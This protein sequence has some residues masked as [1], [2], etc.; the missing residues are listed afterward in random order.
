M[1]LKFRLLGLFLLFSLVAFAQRPMSVT[2]VV[3]FIKS[4]IKSN[5][6]DRA[7]ADYLRK[8]KLTQHL[9]DR[10]IEELQGQGA[11]P[12]TVAALKKLSAESASL[13]AAPPVAAAPPPPPLPPPPSA[14]EQ[15]QILS[16]MREYALSYTKNLPNYV[17]IQTTHRRQQGTSTRPGYG[18]V[19]ADVIQE[20]LTFYDKKET[21]KV[22]SHDGQSVANV[23]HDQLGG[24]RSS[25]EFGTMLAQI[26]DP[27][28]GA[29]FAWERWA[30][31]RGR[32]M[33]VF[34]YS[35]GKDHGYSMLDEE[36]HR[37]YT[38]AYKGEIYFDRDLKAIMVVKL[39]T[40]NI[41]PDFPIKE[42]HIRLDYD[43]IKVGEQA[44]I[45]PYHYQLDSKAD[46]A[47]GSNEADFKLYQKY[48]AESSITFGDTAP[49][50]PNSLKDE[51]DKK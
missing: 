34:S 25:G 8:I 7:T 12:A 15:Q 24:I 1:F 38:S 47:D 13:P 31:L 19:M 2:E 11:G 48:G 35:I 43:L 23:T 4:Q 37:E 9:E 18:G 39:D 50:D 29:N 42:V 40:M 14:A 46:R 5:G 26:F 16:D 32:R 28:S 30:T 33:Y 45:L 21:Y 49:V 36:S 10:T 20:Q 3:S 51:P 41:P 27:D 22:L 6:D 17:C 44:Y